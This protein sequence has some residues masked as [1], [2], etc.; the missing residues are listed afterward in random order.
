MDFAYWWNFISEGSATNKASPSSFHINTHRICVSY[1]SPVFKNNYC[2]RYYQNASAQA[3]F[4]SLEKKKK[5]IGRHFKKVI[6]SKING[7]PLRKNK[8]STLEPHQNIFLSLIGIRLFIMEVIIRRKYISLQKNMHYTTFFFK[9]SSW[10][11]EV[12]LQHIKISIR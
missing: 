10:V 1:A 3:Q 6:L 4:G 11:I 9:Q 5:K 8:I 2:E 7:S 12:G